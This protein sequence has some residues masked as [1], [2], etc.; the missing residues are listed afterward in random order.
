[1]LQ[2]F[3][4][5]LFFCRYS[6]VG[7]T[8]DAV[9]LCKERFCIVVSGKGQHIDWYRAFREALQNPDAGQDIKKRYKILVDFLDNTVIHRPNSQHG[10]FSDLQSPRQDQLKLPKYNPLPS[11]KSGEIMLL[12]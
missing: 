4:K 9:C 3:I 11:I 12:Q 5:S 8:F 6:D 1:M 7:Y 2:M 10:K